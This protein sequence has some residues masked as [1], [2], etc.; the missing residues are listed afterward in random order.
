MINQVFKDEL[1]EKLNML[2]TEEQQEV[3]DFTRSLADKKLV[4]TPKR[5]LL[6]FAGLIDKEDLNLMRRVIEEDCERVD[7]NEW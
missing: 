2:S 4:G 1:L 6:K 5:E 3:L 7:P